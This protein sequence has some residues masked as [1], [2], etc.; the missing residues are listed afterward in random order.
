MT[1]YLFELL[2]QPDPTGLDNLHHRLRHVSQLAGRAVDGELATI[3][4]ALPRFMVL[5]AIA[6]HPGISGAA[7][8]KITLQTPQSLTSMVTVLERDGLV[9]RAPGKGRIIGHSLTDIGEASIAEGR[10][11]L[12]DFQRRLFVELGPERVSRM[13][14]D[15]DTFANAVLAQQRQQIHGNVS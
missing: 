9:L 6:R 14:A 1:D 8:A 3:D 10:S 11:I 13:N 15:L 5:T 12:E 7:L 4:L 2:A